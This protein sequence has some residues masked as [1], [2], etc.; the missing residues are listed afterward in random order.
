MLSAHPFVCRENLLRTGKSAAK[1]GQKGQAT[2]AG[3]D[4]SSQLCLATRVLGAFRGGNQFRVVC[5]GC[6]GHL[7]DKPR[8]CDLIDRRLFDKLR[9]CALINR[10]LFDKRQTCDLI[11]R[12]LFD[13]SHTFNLSDRR[14]FDKYHTCNLADRYLFDKP[15]TRALINRCLFAC[16][17]F[18]R[19]ISRGLFDS[20]HQRASWAASRMVR[21]RLPLW[22]RGCLSGK[23]KSARISIPLRP[24]GAHEKSPPNA[25]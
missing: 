16:G 17:E 25:G 6:L 5:A 11:D 12:F 10:C 20:G 23:D 7:F 24:I 1:K 22:G 9:T 15:R 19:S 18:A 13:K 4:R 21:H 8:F 14:L 3:A 2:G